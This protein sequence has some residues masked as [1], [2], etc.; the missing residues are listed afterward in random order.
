MYVYVTTILLEKIVNVK[1]A[2]T[3][4]E[5]TA[6]NVKIQQP[7]LLALVKRMHI[8]HSSINYVFQ[9]HGICSCGQCFCDANF[10]GKH[11]N[12]HENSCPRVNGKQCNGPDHGSCSCGK[13]ICNQ[14]Y[15]GDD[16]SCT[17]S[18]ETCT[19]PSD[20]KLVCS[21]HGE[22]ACGQCNCHESYYGKF[23][24]K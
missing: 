11:C 14:K 22:C 16:C 5:L 13:C 20:S 23:C 6:N 21:G 8:D 19:N 15:T 3:L 12:C 4:K 9:G 1:L 2:S 17:T 24:D 18:Q 10:S 7:T